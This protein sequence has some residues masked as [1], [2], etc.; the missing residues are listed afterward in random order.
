MQTDTERIMAQADD[1]LAALQ[2]DLAMAN[3]GAQAAARTP[4]EAPLAVTSS[5][6]DAMEEPPPTVIGERWPGLPADDVEV[7]ADPASA[8]EHRWED[9]PQRGRRA[10]IIVVALA[11]FVAPAAVWTHRH[12]EQVSAWRDRLNGLLQNALP[13]RPQPVQG[14]G[15][16][17]PVE[18]TPAAQPAATPPI[19]QEA[20][21]PSAPVS[22]TPAEPAPAAN[23]ETQAVPEEPPVTDAAPAPPRATA[24]PE[25]RSRARASSKSRSANR[26]RRS[27]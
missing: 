19:A 8:A 9:R 7:W 18:A 20:A 26:P 17:A 27:Q 10:L 12:P 4:V 16:A 21:A 22:D 5:P 25:T 24:P 2:R 15:E 11:F 3:A 13:E 23:V 1:M 6:A 14:S